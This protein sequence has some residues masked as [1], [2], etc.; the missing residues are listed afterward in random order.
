MESYVTHQFSKLL[1]L[2]V[3]NTVCI[4]LE[5][6]LFNW[7]VRRSKQYDDVPTWENKRFRSRYKHKFVELKQNLI[8]CPENRDN[9]KN[10]TVKTFQ[11]IEYS[12]KELFPTGPYA[13]TQERLIYRDIRKQFL[14]KESKNQEGFFVCG[15][16][17]SNKTTY[18]QM[19]TRSA[20][21]PMTVFVSCHNCE[22]NWK[23]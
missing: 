8:R 5:R 21:E 19:Q 3:D 15:R 22:R 6:C 23:C 18:F 1:D 11:F 20:D 14:S 7:S 4:N 10:G 16:C 13:R 2:P 9:L 12:P 17:K